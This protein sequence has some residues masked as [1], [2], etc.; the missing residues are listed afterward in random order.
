MD[1][2]QHDAE[3]FDTDGAIFQEKNYSKKRERRGSNPRND[4]FDQEVVMRDAYG[5]QVETQ[6]QKNNKAIVCLC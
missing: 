3:E 6:E 4:N 2:S 1:S 5:R